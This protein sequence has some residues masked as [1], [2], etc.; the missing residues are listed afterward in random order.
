MVKETTKVLVILYIVST[1]VIFFLGS[2]LGEYRLEIKYQEAT[3]EF[4]AKIKKQE[5]VLRAKLKEKTNE[6]NQIQEDNRN[7]IASINSEHERLLRLAETKASY[8]RQLSS[9]PRNGCE[10][11]AGIATEYNQNLT[12]G[13]SVVGR[14][15]EDTE[16]LNRGTTTLIELIDIVK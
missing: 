2:L 4:Q 15:K 10:K 11:L 8:Y 9:D 12:R 14:L 5:D 1:L 3:I 6:L 16:S 7:A 13:V